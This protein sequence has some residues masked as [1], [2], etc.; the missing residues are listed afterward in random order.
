MDR[1]TIWLYYHHPSEKWKCLH[2]RIG[3]ERTLDDVLFTLESHVNFGLG[4]DPTQYKMVI[5][6][7]PDAGVRRCDKLNQLG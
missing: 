7:P 3:V 4:N 2:F 6:H 5:A 1:V